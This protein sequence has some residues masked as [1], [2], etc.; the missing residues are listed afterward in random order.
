MVCFNN[1]NSSF[2]YVA[3]WS[4]FKVSL[5]AFN[6]LVIWYI[7]SFGNLILSIWMPSLDKQSAYWF[8]GPRMWCTI[9]WYGNVHIRIFCN[10]GVAWFKLLD[11]IASKGFW[12]VFRM[13]WVPY[14]KWWN[15]SMAHTTAKD[16]NLITTY[17]FWVSVRALMAKYTGL[18]CCIRNAP[19]PLM[20]SVCLE[21]CFFVGVVVC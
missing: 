2:S 5:L 3:I 12:S 9:K 7:C 17:P 11:R 21:N 4:W 14:R 18:P 20:L 1:I 13:K 10:H 6:W 16:S 8:V 15:F 19:N